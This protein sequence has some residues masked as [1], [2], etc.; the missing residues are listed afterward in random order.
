MNDLKDNVTDS[1]NNVEDI[2]VDYSH[3][4]SEEAVGLKD[5]V[6]G[7][8]NKCSSYVQDNPWKSVSISLLVGFVLSRILKS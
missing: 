1:V 3:K 5:K 4:I 8:T 7:T 6:I 2:L